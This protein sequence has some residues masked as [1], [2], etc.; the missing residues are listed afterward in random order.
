[1]KFKLGRRP[2][3]IDPRTFSLKR[4]FTALPPVPA[5]VDWGGKVISW[6]MLGNDSLGDC[7]EASAL[8]LEMDWT[9][10][11]STEF[12]PTTQDAIAAYSAITGYNPADPSSDQGTVLLDLLNYWRTTGIA[13]HK[14]YA[15]ATIDP[16]NI[17]ELMAAVSFFGGAY[18][19]VNLPQSALDATEAG[20]QWTNATDTNIAGGH[21]IPIV[22]YDQNSLT[23]ITWGQ[24]QTMTWTWL[25]AYLDE[26]YAIFSPDWVGL[27][28]AAPSGFN[29]YQLSGDLAAL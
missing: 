1:M 29:L 20:Q 22:A 27:N 28:G 15:Y 26:A 18:L 14:I 17:Q 3:R 13:G 19:G 5:S 21:A 9:S 12:L 4:Y 16:A 2:K 25:K 23:C 11:A 8:H 10:N 6:E 7:G 24:P